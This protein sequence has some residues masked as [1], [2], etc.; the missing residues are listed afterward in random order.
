MFTPDS[1][2]LRTLQGIMMPSSLSDALPPDL[3]GIAIARFD[4]LLDAGELFYQPPRIEIVNTDGMQVHSFLQ[5]RLFTANAECMN[6][7]SRREDSIQHYDFTLEQ[8][9]PRCR[10]SWS[11]QARRAFYR[12]A[13]RMDFG[14]NWI[15]V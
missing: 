13:R 15:L 2:S 3:E 11:H 5:Q 8:A 14:P 10:C 6:Q 12:P 4:R 7:L 1:F 9:S